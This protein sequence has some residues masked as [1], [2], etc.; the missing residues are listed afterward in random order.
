MIR[1]DL[2]YLKVLHC[3]T[4]T[5][6]NCNKSFWSKIA[7]FVCLKIWGSR[8]KNNLKMSFHCI[9]FING[10]ICTDL[11]Q[12]KLMNDI[13]FCFSKCSHVERTE[14]LVSTLR[15]QLLKW[16][17]LVLNYSSLAARWAWSLLFHLFILLI[18]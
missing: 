5:T 17:D 1:P 9:L 15:L 3:S 14:D 6:I 18:W 16:F 11:R 7:R 10:L 4:N 12:A 8:W 13:T 2:T